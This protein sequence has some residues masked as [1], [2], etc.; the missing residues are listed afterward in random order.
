LKYVYEV[1]VIS[2]DRI[3][4]GNLGN[5]K[6]KKEIDKLNSNIIFIKKRLIK[7]MGM[8][9]DI[10]KRQHKSNAQIIN[11]NQCN[12][13]K[14][15]FYWL[16]L[17]PLLLDDP[18]QLNN[19]LNCINIKS[20]NEDMINST[21][22]IIIPGSFISDVVKVYHR[23]IKDLVNLYQDNDISEYLLLS[24]SSPCG[25]LQIKEKNLDFSSINQ[26]SKSTTCNS[27]S[28]DDNSGNNVDNN[29]NN[30]EVDNEKQ[31]LDTLKSVF[32]DYGEGFLLACYN[33]FDNSLERTIDALLTDNL[34]I[35]CIYF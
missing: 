14:T 29:G 5:V 9:L 11:N 15:T 22:D 30:N 26:N 27:S 19:N 35:V 10:S 8:I 3:H 31:I 23:N 25:V 4:A 20:M 24:L 7:C 28:S 6:L 17:L 13:L 21:I 1:Y 16:D 12:E 2:I 32:P 33:S 34:P 18:F